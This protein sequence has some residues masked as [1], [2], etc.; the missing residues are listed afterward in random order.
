[1]YLVKK[2]ILSNLFKSHMMILPV[3]T[4]SD[5]SKHKPWN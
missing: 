4:L 1:M 3:R 5:E 2:Y